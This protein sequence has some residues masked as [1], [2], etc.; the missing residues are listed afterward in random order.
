MVEQLLSAF[1]D[2]M[3]INPS[4][5]AGA[6]PTTLVHDTFTDTDLVTLNTHA[7]DIDTVG[8]GWTVNANLFTILSNKCNGPS[9]TALNIPIIDCGSSDMQIDATMTTPN[10]NSF[11][12][13]IIRYQDFANKWLVLLSHTSN[14]FEL[15]QKLSSSYTLR[16]S[17]AFTYTA[18]TSYAVMFKA[19][20]DVLTATIDG[21][22]EITYTSSLFNTATGVGLRSQNQAAFTGTTIFDD[23]TVTAL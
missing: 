19:V 9:N 23:F 16:D 13:L 15:Y 12:G 4:R 14:Q 21:G 1:G 11:S 20:G 2:K 22:N 6:A 10:G 17:T 18:S 7:P 8:S 5:Y 3:I